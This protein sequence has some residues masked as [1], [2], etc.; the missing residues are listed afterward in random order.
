VVVWAPGVPNGP[1][2]FGDRSSNPSEM[3]KTSSSMGNI[4]L[5]IFNHAKT[6]D[7]WGKTL[8]IATLQEDRKENKY[9]AFHFF[10]G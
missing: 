10:L 8:S 5:I 2:V 7:P 3:E 1:W 6:Y 9:S 4:T